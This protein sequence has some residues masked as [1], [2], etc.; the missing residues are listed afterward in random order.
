MGLDGSAAT[1]FPSSSIGSHLGV[2]LS[3]DVPTDVLPGGDKSAVKP[4]RLILYHPPNLRP[5]VDAL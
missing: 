5:P 1:Q 2:I 3:V 4:N